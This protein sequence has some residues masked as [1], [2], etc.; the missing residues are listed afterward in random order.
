MLRGSLKVGS[1]LG[2]PLYVHWTFWLLIAWIMAG[3]LLMGGEWR[4]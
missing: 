2:I 1:L 4:T 3:P